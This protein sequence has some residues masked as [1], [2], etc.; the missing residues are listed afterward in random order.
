MVSKRAV[1]EAASKACQDVDP[2]ANRHVFCLVSDDQG[3]VSRNRWFT[4]V[5]ECQHL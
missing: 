2:V 3:I 5:I 1:K 4:G